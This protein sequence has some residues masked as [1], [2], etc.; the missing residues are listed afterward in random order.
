MKWVVYALLSIA[1]LSS[2][3]STAYYYKEGFHY[4]E[5]LRPSIQAITFST[6]Q[7][8]I[9]NDLYATKDREF[10]VCLYGTVLNGEVVVN[11]YAV[12][13]LTNDLEHQVVYV[14]CEGQTITGS[15][16]DPI[17]ALLW[18]RYDAHQGLI[19]TLHSH[20]SGN[21]DP[22]DRDFQRLGSLPNHHIMGVIC[23]PNQVRVFTQTDV[24]NP[25]EAIIG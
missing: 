13:S 14:P 7:M 15:A 2:V 9:L 10:Q 25:V 11:N 21:C 6:A 5:S 18:W 12:S 4:A 24:Q 19:G 20:P 8:A 16:L 17:E 1:L 23:G 22:S 3:Y